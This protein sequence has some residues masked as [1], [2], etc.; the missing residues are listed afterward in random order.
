M[1]NPIKIDYLEV[2]LFLETP[3]GTPLR[4][5]NVNVIHFIM[6]TES[7]TS[8]LDC[9]RPHLEHSSFSLP[10]GVFIR[11]QSYKV[12]PYQL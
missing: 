6:L 10:I 7:S 2:P 3:I 1:E 12:G 9:S 8:S 4:G 5:L 11:A